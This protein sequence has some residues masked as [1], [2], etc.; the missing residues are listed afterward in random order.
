[1][2]C[3]H[4]G[5]QLPDGAAFCGHCGKPIPVCEK[6][7]LDDATSSDAAFSAQDASDAVPA[8]QD[9]SADGGAA[10][11]MKDASAEEAASAAQ[12]A[13]DS[14]GSSES[15]D[16]NES[17][18]EVHAPKQPFHVTR[19]MT[20]G[21]LAV[22][23]VAVVAIVLALSGAFSG[24]GGPS[25][26]AQDVAD[27]VGQL[28]DALMQSDFDADAFEAFGSGVIDLMPPEVVDDALAEQG[29]TRDEAVEEL[30]VTLG[31]A[32][33][34]YGSLV[35]S[36]ADTFTMGL[37]VQLGDELTTSEIED[38]NDDLSSSGC[39]GTVSEGYYLTGTMVITF[40]ADFQGYSAGDEETM[41]VGNIG[42]C[43]VKI[44][45]SWYLWGGTY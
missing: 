45:G 19:G 2:F 5:S 16:V 14:T 15:S 11:A 43:A 30:G 22:L 1:M 10:P 41:D 44:D 23:A 3:P 17:P 20:I 26:S 4:C 39:S 25:R 13:S 40:G 33:Q 28:Y 8:A 21:V 37:D 7:P 35:S 9:V 42:L 27:R 38:I 18:I 32:M 12:G 34:S 24:G 29:Y 6:R 31:G 36:F